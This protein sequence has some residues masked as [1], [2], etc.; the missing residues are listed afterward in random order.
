[1][2]KFIYRDRDWL[3]EKYVTQRKSFDTISKETG[4]NRSTIAKWAYK[5]KIP[6]R[7]ISESHIGLKPHNFKGF[8]FSNGY[9][10]TY[11][12]KKKVFIHRKVMEET[13]KRKLKK[14]EVVHHINGIITDNRPE[15]LKLCKS[16]GRHLTDEHHLV[17][18]RKI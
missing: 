17:Y 3:F 15:N 18:G 6:I 10:E 16:A 7:D 14:G 2:N 5:L 11:I 4:I 1:M 12:N 8:H 13:L 9:I